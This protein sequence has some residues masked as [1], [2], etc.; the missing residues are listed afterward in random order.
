V[1]VLS[2]SKKAFFKTGFPQ[3]KPVFFTLEEE[4]WVF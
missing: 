4:Q 2:Y 1:V 3:P